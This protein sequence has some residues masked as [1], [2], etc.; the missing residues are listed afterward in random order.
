MRPN[1]SL[2][3]CQKSGWSLYSWRYS[4]SDCKLCEAT[5]SVWPSLKEGDGLAVS[6][7]PFQNPSSATLKLHD[8]QAI[9]PF[10]DHRD[11]QNWIIIE[12]KPSENS[13]HVI[14]H[15]TGISIKIFLLTNFVNS[16]ALVILYFMKWCWHPA[17]YSISIYFL[18]MQN[19][20]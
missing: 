20:N 17:R 15:S 6:R 2:T 16:T 3:G 5:S 9:F 1:T 12:A 19:F 7:G 14:K 4:K 18:E 13:S 8:Q 10:Q 11:H